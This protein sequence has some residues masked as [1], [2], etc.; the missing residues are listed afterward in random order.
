MLDVTGVDAR[1]LSQSMNRELERNCASCIAKLHC[2]DEIGHGRAAQELHGLLPECADAE[3]A[4][5][6]ELRVGLARLWRPPTLRKSALYFT[7][8]NSTSKISVA[9]G[10]IT[11]PAPCAP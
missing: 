7:P 8:S 4:A 11:P 1:K 2:A 6:L 5:A 9:F 3:R 10:G